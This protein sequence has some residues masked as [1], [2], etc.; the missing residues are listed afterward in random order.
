MVKD[1][2]IMVLIIIAFI[3]SISSAVGVYMLYDQMNSADEA[4]KKDVAKISVDGEPFKGSK[5]APV[6]IIEFSDFQCPYCARFAQQT[7]PAIVKNYVDAGKVKIVFKDF[8]LSFHANAK[9]AAEAANCAAEQGKFWEYHD[10]I[11]ENQ[12]AL[13]AASLKK[14]AKDLSLDSSKFDSC[15]D[16]DK[17]VSEIEQD[18]AEGQQNGVTGTPAF[19]VNGKEITGA[20]PYAVF[21]QAI[22]EALG[23]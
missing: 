4:P 16:S 7:M 8:P 20:Q 3:L 17:Y 6:T 18:V 1:R 14:Y 15:L 5:N 21:E 13:D 10:K 19:F 9:N 22:N 23:K 11:F 2:L 12:N